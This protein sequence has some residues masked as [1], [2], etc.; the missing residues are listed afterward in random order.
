[1]VKRDQVGMPTGPTGRPMTAADLPPPDTKRWVARRKAEV[2]FGI[3]AG[4]ITPEEACRRYR[5]S[6]D[7]LRS[8][9]DLIE[10]HG[11]QGLRVT[12][13]QRYRQSVPRGGRRF[14]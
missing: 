4:L 14:E 10:R 2:V 5:I 7:E 8:W 13:L 12:R 9:Q 11:M 3:R 1:M 6:P